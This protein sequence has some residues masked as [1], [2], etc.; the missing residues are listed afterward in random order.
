M[1]DGKKVIVVSSDDSSYDDPYDATVEVLVLDDICAIVKSL[2]GEIASSDS[3]MQ[4]LLD[5]RLF[6]DFLAQKG[7]V[8]TKKVDR[9]SGKVKMLDR[10]WWTN[11]SYRM[12]QVDLEKL[13]LYDIDNLAREDTVLLQEIAKACIGKISPGSHKKILAKK[14]AIKE[15]KDKAKKIAQARADK[16]KA[17]EIE[18]AKKLLQDAGEID[19]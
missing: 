16:K 12:N 14:R 11:D 4:L 18:K 15:K 3:S 5:N 10:F 13:S 6:S 17:K 1:L 7:Y 8:D 2:V 9:I 19:G